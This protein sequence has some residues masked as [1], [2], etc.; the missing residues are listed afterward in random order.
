MNNPDEETAV[1]QFGRGDKYFGICTLLVTMPGL[2]MFGHG[3]IEGFEEKYGMEY[4]RSYRDEKPDQALIDRHERE[5]FPLLKRRHVYSGSADFCLYDLY[6]ARGEINENVF[7]YSN[8]AGEERSL[9]LYNNAY[10]ET[11]GWINM[12][13]V[14][15]RRKDGG[16][17][18]DKLCQALGLHDRGAWFTLLKEQRQDLWYIRSS[19]E[20]AEQG[21]F[22]SLR[23][24]EAQVFID[25]HETKDDGRGRFARLHAE[26]N[27][28]GVKDVEAAIQDIYLG[29]LY[30]RLAGLF[31]RD[32]LDGLFAGR[33]KKPAGTAPEGGARPAAGAGDSLK[34]LVLDFVAVARKFLDGALYEPFAVER[35][36]EKISGERIWAEFAAYLERLKAVTDYGAASARGDDTAAIRFLR[37]LGKKLNARPALIVLAY[38]YGTL[39]LLRSIIGDGASGL[40]ARALGDHWALDRK[41][42]ENL[43]AY[44]PDDEATG[45]VLEIMKALLSRTSPGESRGS[46]EGKQSAAASPAVQEL[47]PA[48]KLVLDN[49]HAEDFRRLLGV[50]IFDGVIW[51]NKE[52]FEETLFYTSLF[53]ALES[54]AALQGPSRPREEAEGTRAEET[55]EWLERIATIA[56]LAEAFASAE[57]ASAYRLDGLLKALETGG[58]GTTVTAGESH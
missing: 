49:Y 57:Q 17:R 48:E 26:L 53:T 1:A 36:Y 33:R 7:A 29:E 12:S 51:F 5:I 25:I 52:A 58:T 11:A 24:Y 21:L 20:I 45:R 35:S 38:A 9:A 47:S 40:E 42:R 28:R 8:R 16:F 56:E 4:R 13:A 23:G 2:P 27:G 14:A 54:K 43:R 55:A 10:D 6:T 31:S 22:V 50:N 19:K 41:L 18:R 32:H 39:S 15:V 46:A 30:R 3:Q 34:D 37:S 44:A